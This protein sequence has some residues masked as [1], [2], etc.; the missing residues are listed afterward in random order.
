LRFNVDVQSG[1]A[2]QTLEQ[3]GCA[4]PTALLDANLPA[5]LKPGLS[6]SSTFSDVL[7]LAN[8]LIGYSTGTAPFNLTTQRRPGR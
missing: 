3:I 7:A 8:R 5:A 6:S 2:G 4:V 1:F